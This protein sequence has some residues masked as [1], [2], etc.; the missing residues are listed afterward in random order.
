M[1]KAERA[2]IVD[3]LKKN[4]DTI[5]ELTLDSLIKGML[6]PG[7]LEF[8]ETVADMAKK[9]KEKLQELYQYAQRIVATGKTIDPMEEAALKIMQNA[10][11]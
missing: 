11:T 2:L 10:L 1:V 4:D 3:F 5:N 6:P 8:K 7:A 9:D